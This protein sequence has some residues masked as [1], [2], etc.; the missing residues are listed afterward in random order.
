MKRL[1]KQAGGQTGVGGKK[2]EGWSTES[3]IKARHN[4][5]KVATSA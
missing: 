1:M 4:D 2:H 5:F 3:N